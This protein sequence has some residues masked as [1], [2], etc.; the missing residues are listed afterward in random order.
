[1]KKEKN[2]HLK[3]L[4]R[5]KILDFLMFFGRNKIGFKFLEDKVHYTIKFLTDGMVNFHETIEGK[6]KKYPRTGKLD[7]KKFAQAKETLERE[8]PNILKEIDI[9]DP[10]YE[11]V[12]VII[13]PTRER[14]KRAIEVKRKEITV[15][16]N[17][18]YDMFFSVSMKDLQDYDFQVAFWAKEGEEQALL[19]IDGKYFLL[20]VDDFEK[21][22]DKIR[23]RLN[24]Q[25][26]D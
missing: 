10:K 22:F 7:I 3:K 1:M 26:F 5:I 4:K 15:K 23:K 8:L 21:V 11:N 14:I 19:R 25:G 12:V 13:C 17:N 24:I 20:K 9:N 2:E 16:K 18:F 6:E